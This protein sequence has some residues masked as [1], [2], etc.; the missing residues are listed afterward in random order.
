MTFDL[1]TAVTQGHRIVRWH[2][3]AAA[4][5]G[6]TPIAIADIAANA[7]IAKF[8]IRQILVAFQ[9]SQKQIGVMDPTAQLAIL[10]VIR[11][12]GVARVRGMLGGKARAIAAT[13]VGGRFAVRRAVRFIPL[14]GTV[15]SASLSYLAIRA[16]GNEALGQCVRIR[17]DLQR[18][19][20]ANLRHRAGL[21]L[22]TGEV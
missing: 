17:G 11:R 7:M 18:D 9:L 8:M 3:L 21:H 20:S 5:V 15:A 4:G 12:Q 2:A 10:E 14:L 6:A 22:P 13:G 1:D 19:A 16:I